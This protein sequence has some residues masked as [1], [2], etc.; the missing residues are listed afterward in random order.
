MGQGPLRRP[1]R[2]AAAARRR[3]GNHLGRPPKKCR[4]NARLLREDDDTFILVQG[5]RGSGKRDV[6]DQAL[7]QRQVKL[8]IDCKAIQDARGDSAKIAAAAQQVGY[9]PLFSWMNSISGMIDLAAQS[10]TGAKLGFSETLDSQL[11][12]IWNTTATALRQ[13]ALAGRQNGDSDAHVSAAEY[14]EA[15]PE[16]RPVVVIDNFFPKRQ[17]GDVICDK[18][19]EWFVLPALQYLAHRSGLPVSPRPTSPTSSS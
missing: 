3:R 8:V 11:A 6:V 14:L 16:H 4:P 12:K 10:A 13:L 15:H 18:L 9:R 5:P 7:K 1:Y 19:A 17:D 2:G